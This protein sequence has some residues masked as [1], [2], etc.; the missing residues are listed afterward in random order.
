[1]ICWTGCQ[2]SQGF[3]DFF[4]PHAGMEWYNGLQSLTLGEFFL[5]SW[6]QEEGSRFLLLLE[7]SVMAVVTIICPNCNATIKSEAGI[8]LGITLQC[9]QCSQNFLVEEKVLAR[10][11]ILA[12]RPPKRNLAAPVAVGVGVPPMHRDSAG[13]GSWSPTND[14]ARI[15]LVDPPPGGNAGE[16]TGEAPSPGRSGG[17]V[18]ALLGLLLLG[19][20]ITLAIFHFL[21]RPAA[22]EPAA[23]VPVLPP[24]RKP[25]HSPVVASVQP[26]T[27]EEAPRS[28]STPPANSQTQPGQETEPE[29]EAIRQGGKKKP[30]VPVA[31]PPK[32]SPAPIPEKSEIKPAVETPKTQAP[33]K[34]SRPSPP[35][36]APPARPPEAQLALTLLPPLEQQR[37]HAAVARGT[38][39][40]LSKQN[41]DGTWQAGGHDV[42][43]AA[44][45]AL[46]LLECGAPPRHPAVQKAAE[47]VRIHSARLGQTYD[48][49]L[50]IMFL[51]R[52]GDPRDR[53][54]IQTLAMRL[55]AGQL[56]NGGWG[57]TCP[58][59]TPE[60]NYHLYTFLSYTRP[61]PVLP[62][63]L[64]KDAGM[65]NPLEKGG[66]LPDP[67]DKA[68]SLPHPLEKGGTFP[69]PLEKGGVFPNPL[70]KGG[71]FPNPLEKS[72]TEPLPIGWEKPAELLP[73]LIEGEPKRL[74]AIDADRKPDWKDPKKP[75]DQLG[76]S[77]SGNP[78]D[79]P[80]A[81]GTDP[82]T[83]PSGQ[84]SNQPGQGQNTMPKAASPPLEPG[85]KVP[86]V[87]RE[88]P[89]HLLMPSVQ[90]LPIVREQPE[91]KINLN[92]KLPNRKKKVGQFAATRDDNSNS[93]FAIMGLWIARRHGIP[94][95][96]TIALVEQ[97]YHHTQNGDGGWSYRPGF[98]STPAMTCVGLMGLAIGHGTTQEI[99]K[100]YTAPVTEKNRPGMTEEDPAIRKALTLLG[101]WV[102]Q[103]VDPAQASPPLGNLYYLWSLER[104][105]MMYNLRTIGNKDWYR[106]S[107]QMLVAHQKADGSWI[108]G[109]YPGSNATVDTCLA[110]LV[111]RRANLT[112]DLTES[113]R[114]A[115]PVQ[116]PA[117]PKR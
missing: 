58:L 20:G 102:G 114:L 61:V 5:R 43:Y 93:Q 99:L 75:G 92:F 2:E 25:D 116:D 70:E 34:S 41:K 1:M 107:A 111:L 24:A 46:T 18:L 62:N 32:D 83:N 9:L 60:E 78:G 73:I 7:G 87:F 56:E 109:H 94:M 81:S 51:D 38:N 37:V 10:E 86:I 27:T 49:G 65:P 19:G 98:G 22:E 96:R 31:S 66:S 28:V 50:A 71:V 42:G 82:K 85:Q 11:G 55:I 40:L 80:A 110:L 63:P 53:P 6:S 45:P 101:Q 100:P 35:S 103:P 33:P 13:G 52:L 104:V 117:R 74:P 72:G 14:G 17:M 76:E 8:P 112:S 47:Y 54:L 3:A 36:A 39:W 26:R 115:M 68:A 84:G 59:L 29:I 95:E 106:W 48:L 88:F 77:R 108:G 91:L 21:P 4:A 57:Y 79:R 113:L 64:T 23:K 97:R 30:I 44:L 69:N 105:A 16:E 15:S 90:K 12:A 67:L 89:R